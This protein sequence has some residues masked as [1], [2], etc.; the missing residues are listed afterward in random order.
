MRPSPPN[1]RRLRTGSFLAL[2]SVTVTI[3]LS[4][5]VV[6]VATSGSVSDFVIAGGITRPSNVV[7][8][9]VVGLLTTMDTSD[10]ASFG[11]VSKTVVT[12][13]TDVVVVSVVVVGDSVAVE[14]APP[15]PSAPTVAVSV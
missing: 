9:A 15:M 8:V 2:D 1:T 4:R 10:D 6:Y 5:P 7:A 3:A 14:T 12:V 13:R 11:D